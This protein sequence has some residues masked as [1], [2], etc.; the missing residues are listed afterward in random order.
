MPH[1]VGVSAHI[2]VYIHPCPEWD[3]NS[4]PVVC[5]VKIWRVPLW[6]FWVL[7]HSI[8]WDGWGLCQMCN[9]SYLSL[10]W[11]LVR[12]VLCTTW[13]Y[14]V[15][16]TARGQLFFTRGSDGEI[17]MWPRTGESCKEN[18]VFQKFSNA[19]FILLLLLLL[20]LE[21]LPLCSVNSL[22]TV[23]TVILYCKISACL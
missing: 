1:M 20:L 10:S 17:S 15:V 18:F 19:P 9:A 22:C 2:L 16:C 4:E 13:R 11:L 14:C 6:E 5:A 8:W 21:G 3:W 7:E 12:A 23:D